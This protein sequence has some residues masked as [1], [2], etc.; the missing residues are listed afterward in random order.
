M[1]TRSTNNFS[2]PDDVTRSA[3]SS[4]V[5]E[6]GTKERG[7]GSTLSKP[8][9]LCRGIEGLA[10]FSS[11]TDGR[12]RASR[13]DAPRAKSRPCNRNYIS[14]K[15]RS[16][17]AELHLPRSLPVVE[18][19]LKPGEG[20]NLFTIVNKMRKNCT[21]PSNRQPDLPLSYSKYL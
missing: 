2:R 14:R 15:P 8:W 9:P 11:L 17:S 4:P 21:V 10:F 1:E 20:Q 16:V 6:D 5:F 7:S 3:A 12:S 13:R 19:S 18:E